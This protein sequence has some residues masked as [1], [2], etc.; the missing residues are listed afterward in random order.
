MRYYIFFGNSLIFWKVK[1]QA[2]LEDSQVINL[3]TTYLY[4]NNQVALYIA[5][6]CYI[7]IVTEFR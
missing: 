4:C 1:R 3:D 6:S 5:T 7:V 2:N